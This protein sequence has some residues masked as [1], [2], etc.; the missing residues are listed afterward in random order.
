MKVAAS[1]LAWI[2][3]L[4]F[5]PAAEKEQRGTT[6]AEIE[7][8]D[9]YKK[10]AVGKL[11]EIAIPKRGAPVAPAKLSKEFVQKIEKEFYEAVEILNTP[12]PQKVEWNHDHT[13]TSIYHRWAGGKQYMGAF[14][15][16]EA[17]EIRSYYFQDVSALRVV[18]EIKTPEER[19]KFAADLHEKLFGVKPIGRVLGG[20]VAS[21]KKRAGWGTVVNGVPL[22][23]SAFVSTER[24]ANEKW[25]IQ[26]HRGV[27]KAEVKKVEDHFNERPAKITSRE[28]MAIAWKHWKAVRGEGHEKRTLRMHAPL[29]EVD[30]DEWEP[31]KRHVNFSR[32][33]KATSITPQNPDDHIYRVVEMWGGLFTVKALIDRQDG[34]VVRLAEEQLAW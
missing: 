12:E 26:V 28:A 5:A 1:L 29:Y 11:E 16:V 21:A 6:P 2:C 33:W 30:L 20:G 25:V 19:Q 17:G 34:T 22:R 10:L 31:G 18:N 3:V 23:K 4:S 32:C 27:T 9:E 8:W 15:D 7:T 14:I 24:R 13:S